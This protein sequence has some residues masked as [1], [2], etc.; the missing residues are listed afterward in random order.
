MGDSQHIQ[1]YKSI[2]LLVKVEKKRAVSSDRLF[3]I[4]Y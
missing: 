3:S 4:F 1:N 2:K